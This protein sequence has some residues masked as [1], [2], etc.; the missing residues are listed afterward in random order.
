MPPFEEQGEGIEIPNTFSL[1]TASLAKQQVTAESIP[2]E[3]PTTALEKP[4]FLI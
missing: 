3:R 4:H 1:P 2:P